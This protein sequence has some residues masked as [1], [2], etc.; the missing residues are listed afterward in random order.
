MVAFLRTLFVV[1]VVATEAKRDPLNILSES[2]N[3]LELETEQFQN[4]LTADSLIKKY[5]SDGDGLLVG[6]AT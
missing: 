4:S 2:L 3:A 1:A 5:D 6:I